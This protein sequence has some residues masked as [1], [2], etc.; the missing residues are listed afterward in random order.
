M[1][2]ILN[3]DELETGLDKAIVVGGKSYTMTPF[4]VEDFLNNMREIEDISQ[5][6][7]TGADLYEKS[8]RMVMKA[9]PGLPQD[10]MSKLNTHQVEAIFQF[11]KAQ[12][13]EEAERITKDASEGNVTGEASS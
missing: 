4:S 8:L 3:V 9:F 10:V 6:E 11:M 5:Q 12:T 7:L 13:D 1:T 2:K